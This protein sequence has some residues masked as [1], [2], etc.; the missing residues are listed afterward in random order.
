MVHKEERIDWVPH[1]GRQRKGGG[2]GGREEDRCVKKWRQKASLSVA[3]EEN[4]P[5]VNL[6]AC[7]YPQEAFKKK[8]NK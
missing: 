2:G 6:F 7:F 8:P 3:S 5:K 1:G 4:L